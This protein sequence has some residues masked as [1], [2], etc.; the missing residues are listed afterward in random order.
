MTWLIK[1]KPR[2]GCKANGRRR[3]RRRRMRRKRRRKRR[4]VVIFKDKSIQG[5]RGKKILCFIKQN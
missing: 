3:R 2:K 5:K 4:R 1:P